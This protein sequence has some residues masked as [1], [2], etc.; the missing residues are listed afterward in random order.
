LGLEHYQDHR[1]SVV[2]SIV[3]RLERSWNPLFQ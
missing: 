3:L 2:H 1:Q